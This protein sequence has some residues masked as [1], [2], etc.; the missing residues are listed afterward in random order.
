M[1]I[2][3]WEKATLL[4]AEC[5][6]PPDKPTR[7]RLSRHWYDLYR[8]SQ[9][10]VAERALGQLDLLERVVAHKRFFFAQSW[11]HHET[12]RPGTFRLVPEG[13]RLE[14]LR[15][16]YREMRPMIFGEAPAWDEIVSGL[17]ALE[18][19]INSSRP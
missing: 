5:H 16:D 7:E 10:P 13:D 17:E 14:A 3:P 15:R 1:W 4:H 11:A 18:A 9:Q 19:R 6:R 8:L 12:A 2:F